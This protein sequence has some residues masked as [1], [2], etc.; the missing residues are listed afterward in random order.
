MDQASL[1]RLAAEGIARFPPLALVTAVEWCLDYAEAT[2]DARWSSLGRT[3]APLAAA[4]EDDGHV[5][6][7]VI[8]CI[9]LHLASR[10]P[11]VLDAQTPEEGARLAGLIRE[12]VRACCAS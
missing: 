5:P 4:F 12:A 7:A 9:D 2:G 11:A 1:R 8:D 6:T 10:L 3:L